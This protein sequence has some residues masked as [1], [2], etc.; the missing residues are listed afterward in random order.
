MIFANLDGIVFYTQFSPGRKKR[1]ETAASRPIGQRFNDEELKQMLR[2]EQ[3][4]G[5]LGRGAVG[6]A[7]AFGVASLIGAEV[8]AEIDLGIAV[9]F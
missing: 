3:L 8:A 7:V 9:G 5:L 6:L 4:Y 2:D 1:L